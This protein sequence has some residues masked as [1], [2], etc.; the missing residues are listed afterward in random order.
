VEWVSNYA[1][2]GGLSDYGWHI[3]VRTG[4]YLIIYAHAAPNPPVAVGDI[5]AGGQVIAFSGNT[6]NST[7]AHLHFEMRNCDYQLAGWPYCIIDPTPYIQPLLSAPAP[8]LIDMAPYFQVVPDGVGPF[9]VLQ[10]SN[11]TT[12][13]IQHQIAGGEVFIVKNAQY[14]RL[15]VTG[16][17]IERREDTSHGGGVYYTLDDGYGWSRWCP[18]SWKPGD[19]FMRQPT[20]RYYRKD[21]RKDNCLLMS[22]SP[23]VVSWLRF[24]QHYP[25]WTSPSSNASPGGITLS[26]VAHMVFSWSNNGPPIEQYWFAKNIGLV[27]WKNDQGDHSWI[28]ELPQGRAPL[29]REVVN[30]L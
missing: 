26:N 13:D 17:Y 8:N 22:E 24:V 6:G 3:R 19:S 11:G 14:E 28:S 29:K 2:A 10:H 30:C 9:F 4:K 23:N 20:V 18:K 12:E 27:Q 15:R 21:N 16:Q 25:S 1:P 7:G 5:V